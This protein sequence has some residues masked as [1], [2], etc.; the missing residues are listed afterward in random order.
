MIYETPEQRAAEAALGRWLAPR[1]DLE[2]TQQP[3]LTRI[4]FVAHRGGCT[5]CVVEAKIRPKVWRDQYRTQWIT[6]D[7][8]DGLRDAAWARHL[9][10]LDRC[11][12]YVVQ[13]CDAVG[14]LR[15][16]EVTDCRQTLSLPRHDRPH[17][18]VFPVLQVPTDR[19]RLIL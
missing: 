9:S 6:L 1:W 13:W 15:L 11:C 18:E 12:R 16:S 7:K 8:R 5:V 10:P 3:Q 4:D 2:M 19:F 14:W 17:V